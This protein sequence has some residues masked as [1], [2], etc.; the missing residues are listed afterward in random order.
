MLNVCF[1]VSEFG[2]VVVE[3]ISSLVCDVFCSGLG[4]GVGMGLGLE[5]IVSA[6]DDRGLGLDV[7][8]CCVLGCVVCL[9]ACFCWRVCV[10]VLSVFVVFKF[11]RGFVVR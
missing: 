1:C 7:V 5:V 2:F 9:R 8:A 11:V 6:R 10:V 3:C 4:F